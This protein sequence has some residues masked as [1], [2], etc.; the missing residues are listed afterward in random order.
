M[1]LSLLPA[2]S[3]FIKASGLRKIGY[4]FFT[5][6]GLLFLVYS[7]KVSESA[8]VELS[9]WLLMGVFGANVMEHAFKTKKGVENGNPKSDSEVA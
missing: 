5:Q 8:L 1:L 7:G 9:T 4:A 6:G 2:L 3:E